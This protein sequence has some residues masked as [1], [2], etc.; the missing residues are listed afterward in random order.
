VLFQACELSPSSWVGK[1]C[2][3]ANDCP[4]DYVCAQVRGDSPTCELLRPPRVEKVPVTEQADYCRHIKPILDRSCV[5]GCHGAN[6]TY[7]GAPKDF[8]LDYYEATA[9]G[10]PGAKS[11][12]QRVVSRAADDSMPPITAPEPRIS[13]DE[14]GLLQRW[15][16]SGTPECLDGG[17]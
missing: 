8:R 2:E 9:G 11:R 4:P 3:G 10:L 13:A 16:Q 15:L 7:P 1:T 6:I 5:S 12:A 17:T 14:R